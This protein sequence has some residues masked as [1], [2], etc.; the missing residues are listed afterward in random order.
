MSTALVPARDSLWRLEDDLE[1][2]L[3]SV[4]LVE[5][6]ED[7][8]SLQVQITATLEKTIGKRDQVSAWL[9]REEQHELAIMAEIVRL[10]K[11]KTGVRVRRQNIENYVLDCILAKGPD[12][13]GK[14]P[15]LEGVTS[16]FSAKKNPA[17]VDITA[18][19]DVP[20]EYCSVTLKF[21]PSEWRELADSLD[22]EQYTKLT[23]HIKDRTP[24][25]TPLK[26]KLTSGEAIPGARMAPVKY[27][28]ERE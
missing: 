17:S 8:A 15:A 19:E 28:L 18:T 10:E 24:S 5:T 14:L 23:V 4:D 2:L 7:K 26:L 20:D 3:N 16:R 9:G 1:A 25:K 22:M 13:K 6:D 11:L 21:D 12:A 27:R